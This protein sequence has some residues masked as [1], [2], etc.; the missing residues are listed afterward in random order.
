MNGLAIAL[1][2]AAFGEPGAFTAEVDALAAAVAAVPA[3][4]AT[5]VLLPGDR[6]GAVMARR[7]REGIALPDGTWKRL[8]ASAAALGVALPSLL[9]D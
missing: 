6:G 1:D 5:P 4:G 9:A 8:S 3:S 7:L 2:I